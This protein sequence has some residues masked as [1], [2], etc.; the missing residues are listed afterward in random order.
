MEKT[1]NTVAITKHL[2]CVTLGLL[3]GWL[4]MTIYSLILGF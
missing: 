2:L 1:N 3:S 4:V